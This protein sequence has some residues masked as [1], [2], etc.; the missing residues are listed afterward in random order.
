MIRV[1][2]YAPQQTQFRSKMSANKTNF[3]MKV[4]QPPETVKGLTFADLLLN[5]PKLC[6]SLSDLL[7][8]KPFAEDAATKVADGK[9]SPFHML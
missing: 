9:D 8:Q 4:I 5:P 1:T 6:K 7:P 3:G 2:G